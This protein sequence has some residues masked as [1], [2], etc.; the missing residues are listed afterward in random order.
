[1]ETNTRNQ[2]IASSLSQY[3]VING[4][5]GLHLEEYYK[6]TLTTTKCNWAMHD[7][8]LLSNVNCF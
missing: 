7:E 6:K 1:M 2:V 3:H 5:K 4:V 8:K